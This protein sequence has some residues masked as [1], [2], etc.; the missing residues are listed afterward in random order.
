VRAALLATCAA[1]FAAAASAC[2]VQKEARGFA[3]PPPD[4]TMV[5]CPVSGERCAKTPLTPAAVFE[6]KTYYFCCED[7]PRSFRADPAR[8]ADGP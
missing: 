6:M 4:G 7:C 5:T 8:Y 2:A 3:S 1:L